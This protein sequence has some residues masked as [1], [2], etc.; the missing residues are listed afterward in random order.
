MMRDNRDESPHGHGVSN[1]N[2]KNVKNA[3][4]INQKTVMNLGKIYSNKNI[5]MRDSTQQKFHMNRE[6][7]HKNNGNFYIK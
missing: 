4:N 6:D 1:F 7:D 2:I 5:K 3:L